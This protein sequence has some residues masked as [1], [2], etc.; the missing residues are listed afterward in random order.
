MARE[1]G[2]GTR[3][4]RPRPKG[5]TV[6]APIRYGTLQR[7]AHRTKR[8]TDR[9]LKKGNESKRPEEKPQNKARHSKKYVDRII[10]KNFTTKPLGTSEWENYGGNIKSQGKGI[11]KR[12]QHATSKWGAVSAKRREQHKPPFNTP[13]AL[14][15]GERE[16]VPNA[17]KDKKGHRRSEGNQN[18]ASTKREKEKK[19]S[20]KCPRPSVVSP[21]AVRATTGG[22]EGTAKQKGNSG[23]RYKGRLCQ[24]SEKTLG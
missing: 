9:R 19:E 23:R 15:G 12:K 20:G 18:S 3:R 6:E 14:P 5:S 4:N 1:A 13:T 2:G 22:E 16:S 21:D 8:P 11:T 17:E 24:G 7:G 10:R